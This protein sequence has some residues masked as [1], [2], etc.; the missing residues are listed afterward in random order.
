MQGIGD[1]IIGD[2]GVCDE[3]VSCAS[4][5]RRVKVKVKVAI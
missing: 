5:A 4:L 3:V 1:Y 2:W